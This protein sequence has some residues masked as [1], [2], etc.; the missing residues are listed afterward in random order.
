MMSSEQFVSEFVDLA[1]EAENKAFNEPAGE[2]TVDLTNYEKHDG[3]RGTKIAS[4]ALLGNKIENL[5]VIDIDIN[6]SFD[7]EKNE[8]IR[9][10][11]LQNLSDDDCNRKN[12]IWWITHLLQ[13]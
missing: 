4:K 5:S 12:S 6:K 10:N 3:G 7:E 2:N 9:E 13:H 11:G 8:K 1:V